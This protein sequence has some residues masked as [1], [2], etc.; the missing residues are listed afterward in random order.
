MMT[1][2]DYDETVAAAETAAERLQGAITNLFTLEDIRP[3]RVEPVSSSR[4]REIAEIQIA[5]A[6]LRYP[7]LEP[8]I[9]LV[10]EPGDQAVSLNHREAGIVF[11]SL[12][13]NALKFS[14]KPSPEIRL[15]ASWTPGETVI[16]VEDNG[17]G[18]E[19]D[20][21]ARVFERFVQCGEKSTLSPGVGLGLSLVEKIVTTRGGRI[22]L[23]STPGVRT[24]VRLDIPHGSS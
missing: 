20:D 24:T 2:E 9:D 23:E 8:R 15:T 14:D 12:L 10:V 13:D 16:T 18:I 17:R 5:N 22:H 3:G 6:R 19:F 1:P 7:R 11:G 21:Q 4:L